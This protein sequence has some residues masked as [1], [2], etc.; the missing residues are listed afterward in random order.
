MAKE[1][2]PAPAAIATTPPATPPSATPP[3]DLNYSVR[4]GTALAAAKEAQRPGSSK[5]AVR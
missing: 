2:I 5:P 4:R 3:A 1:T